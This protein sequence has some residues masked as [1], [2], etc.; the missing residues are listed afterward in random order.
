MDPRAL[1]VAFNEQINNRDLEGLAQ[2][3]TDDHTFIDT[4][5]HAIRGTSD[6][7]DASRGFFEAFPDYRN[8]FNRLVVED[9]KVT[10]AAA[11][12]VRTYGWTA[13]RLWVGKAKDDKFAEWRV[14]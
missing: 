4:A 2:L 14:Y 10:V 1:T 5:D 11:R 7:L 8:T 6:C 3:M 9:N 12:V 13:P